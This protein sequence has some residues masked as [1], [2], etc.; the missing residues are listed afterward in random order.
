MKKYR[1]TI[2]VWIAIILIW[3]LITHFKLVSSTLVPSPLQV[4]LTFKKIVFNGY[5]GIPFWVHFG[6]T[7]YRL[8]IA[9]FIAVITGIP[10]AILSGI[11]RT[12]YQVVDSLVQFYKPIPPLAY[13]TILILWFGIGESSKILLLYLAAFAPI[14]L[15]TLEGV[16]SVNEEY[17]F[18][19]QSLG[20]SK[21]YILFHVIF[22]AALPQ[23]FTGIRTSIGVS[24]S[25]LVSAEMVASVS[26]L[27]WM[28][29]DSSK[30][31]KSDVM[32]VGIILLGII[33]YLIDL[34]LKIIQRKYIFWN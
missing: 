23:I 9:I 12:F 19:S 3:S 14:Y 31:L 13:Y 1:I 32:F 10:I 2:L 30:Y 20:A 22:P 21:M 4:L 25:T 24:F 29:I 6:M 28:I 26:G 15:S 8:F 33:G 16:H 34:A 5:N 17:I 27:G 11:S 18:S 7:L